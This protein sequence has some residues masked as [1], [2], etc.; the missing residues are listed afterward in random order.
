M[1]GQRGTAALQWR[2]EGRYVV[3]GDGARSK[4]YVRA[5]VDI[6][7]YEFTACSLSFRQRLEIIEVVGEDLILNAMAEIAS[8]M[9]R[10]FS[11]E[12]QGRADIA[13]LRRRADKENR[14]RQATPT[15]AI[16]FDKCRS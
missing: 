3:T 15:R 10:A 13:L 5:L 9:Q 2:L 7:S 14:Q 16:G 12:Q 11:I 4:V 8:D 6:G 1:S